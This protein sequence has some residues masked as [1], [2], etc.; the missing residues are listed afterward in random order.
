MLSAVP[1][2]TFESLRAEQ[3]KVEKAKR[4]YKTERREGKKYW[5]DV[6]FHCVC[7]LVVE[8]VVEKVHSSRESWRRGE[9]E[10]RN[11]VGHVLTA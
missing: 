4:K 8:K 6:V 1:I 7:M 5:N 2:L 10:R 9:R 11:E 3:E